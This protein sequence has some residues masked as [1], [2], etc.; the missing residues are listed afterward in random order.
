MVRFFFGRV[1]A[2]NYAEIK[3]IRDIVLFKQN[4]RNNFFTKAYKLMIQE[5]WNNWVGLNK[6]VKVF[7]NRYGITRLLQKHIK[8]V[9]Y[10]GI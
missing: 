5:Q 2:V 1:I 10:G 9:Q 8:G 6:E 4:P 3:K 7:R